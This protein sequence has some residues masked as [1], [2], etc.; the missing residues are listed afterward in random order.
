MNEALLNSLCPYIRVANYDVLSGMSS[1]PHGL[2]VPERVIFDYE[3]LFIK[4]GRATITI[5][6]QVYFAKPNDLFLF[7]PGQRHSITLTSNEAFIQPH[8][9]FDFFYQDDSPDIYVSFKGLESM[10]DT[11]KKMFRQDITEQFVPSFPN[12]ITLQDTYFVEQ[13]LFDIINNYKNKPPFYQI[14][15][16]GL[17]LQLWS[18]ILVE[19]MT[20]KNYF[21]KQKYTLIDEIKLYLEHNTDR[22]IT[23]DQLAKKYY[24]N[25]YYINRLFNQ[26]FKKTPIQYHIEIRIHQATKLLLLTNSSVSEISTKVGFNSVSHFSKVFKKIVGLSPTSYRNNII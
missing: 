18:H 20:K 7:K 11:E 1:L 10:T 25:K 19:I 23:M 14:T 12:F 13:F 3:L 2:L 24:V 21:T 26:K 9:H 22:V 17:F 5:E 8:I 16:Q 6:D 15:I 4:S